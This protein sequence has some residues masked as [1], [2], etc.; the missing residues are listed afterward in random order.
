MNYESELVSP[1]DRL[2]GDLFTADAVRSIESGSADPQIWASVE[3]SGFLDALVPESQGG[4]GLSFA[5]VLPLF[6]ALG[7]RAVPLPIG[8]TMIAR[9]ILA[10]AGIDIPDG[11]IALSAP[12]LIVLAAREAE[13]VLTEDCGGVSLQSLTAASL[14]SDGVNGSRDAFAPDPVERTSQDNG[15]SKLVP[16][17]AILTAALIAGAAE[18]AVEMCVEYAGQRIQFG[19]PIGKQQVLQQNLVLATEHVLA[20]RLACEMAAQAADWPLLLPAANAKAI[21][22]QAVPIVAQTAHALHGAIGISAEYD[23]NLLTRRMYAWRLA[24]GA[25]SYWACE[26]GRKV[27]ADSRSTLEVM[28]GE[29]FGA[30]ITNDTDPA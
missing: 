2:L 7:K 20:A 22:A 18:A 11:P 4:V 21:A 23:L 30:S 29:L 26:L 15:S 13:H 19:K 10:E 27:L 25:E 6:L 14:A 28:R 3:K 9:A 17:F 12:S 8:E 16:A 5:N 1:F 24:G